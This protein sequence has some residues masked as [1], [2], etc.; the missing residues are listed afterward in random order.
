M[1]LCAIK[2]KKCYEIAILKAQEI[3]WLEQLESKYLVSWFFCHS[4]LFNL[5]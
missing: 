3:V 1:E 2:N 5:S 4:V